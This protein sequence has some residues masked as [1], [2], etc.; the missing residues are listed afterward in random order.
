MS[1]KF[2]GNKLTPNTKTEK[3]KVKNNRGKN[4]VKQ[5]IK[6]AGRGK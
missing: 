2:F 1:S 6:K 3:G 4:V 5:V